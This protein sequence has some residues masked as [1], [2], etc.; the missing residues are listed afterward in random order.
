MD[1]SFWKAMSEKF[2]YNVVIF[3]LW[4]VNYYC[5]WQEFPVTD[6]REIVAMAPREFHNEI[7]EIN[8]I[9][10]WKINLKFIQPTPLSNDAHQYIKCI[11]ESIDSK[12][13]SNLKKKV[14]FQNEK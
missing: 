3:C 6:M 1:H 12:K 14:K 2:N 9:T 11:I 13:N 10:D 8:N 7:H 4:Q 5:Y